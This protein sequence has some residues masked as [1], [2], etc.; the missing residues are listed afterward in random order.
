MSQEKTTYTITPNLACHVSVACD[1][2]PVLFGRMEQDYI[3]MK[4]GAPIE[5][6][7]LGSVPFDTLPVEVQETISGYFDMMFALT[8]PE[9]QEYLDNHPEYKVIA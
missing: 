5:Q 9:R 7:P 8:I 4:A 6:P 2:F 1:H 3:Y